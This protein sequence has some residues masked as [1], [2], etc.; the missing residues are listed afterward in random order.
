MQNQDM[1][2][3][4]QFEQSKNI[5]LIG[6]TNPDGDCIGSMLG[7]W[8]LLEKQGKKVKYV[9]P[10]AP[11]KIFNFLPDIKK[12]TTNFD[13]ASYDTIVF[14]DLSSY[15]RIYPFSLQ[16]KFFDNQKIIIF[17]HHPGE[18]PKHAILYKD[19]TSS[20]TSELILE[21][22]QKHRKKYLNPTIATYL[23]LG[24][25]TDSGNFVFDENHERIF[26]NALALIKIWAN[27]KMIVDNIIRKKS[28]EQIKFL[29]L[30]I[31]RTTIQSNV[32]CSYYDM[33]DLKK[34]GIDQEEAGYWL[35]VI[36]NIDWPKVTV[37][38]RKIDD[39]IKWSIR[40]KWNVE[41]EIKKNNSVDCNKIAQTFGGG[42]HRWAAWFSVKAQWNT[43]QQIHNIIK[44][45]NSLI[46]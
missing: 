26:T 3:K 31:K 39:V 23:Y 9:T 6:H 34:Y 13:Y 32:L 41:W 4:K 46:A 8:K 37:L 12:I 18:T 29:E 22:A 27:K 33:K 10:T 25:M 45:I 44:K 24:V 30:L 20:S 36:Q 14:M 15:D 16:R 1:K 43:K 11:S 35:M 42:G 21:Y 5:A 38:F 7:L 28:L 17:D 19:S 2:I 40:A